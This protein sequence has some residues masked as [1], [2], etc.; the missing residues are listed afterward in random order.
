MSCVHDKVKIGIRK[1]K[2]KG[3]GGLNNGVVKTC[4]IG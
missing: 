4:E 2:K 3:K 1:E